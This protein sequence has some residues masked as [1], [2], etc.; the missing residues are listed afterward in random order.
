MKAPST[1]TVAAAVGVSVVGTAVHYTDNYLFIDEYPQPDY[2]N[3]EMV[4]LAWVLLTLIGAAG[5]L[6]FREGKQA[7][8]ALY[9]LVYSYTGL[10]SLGHYAFGASHEFTTKM[11]AFIWMDGIVGGAVAVVAL[12][13]FFTRP[14]R[15]KGS[16]YR[17]RP[18]EPPGP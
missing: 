9:L 11:H 4:A 5:Y 1:R 6:L 2:I 16:T 12:W 8:S 10:S 3:K 17:L 13:V 18:E 15:A 14:A 7:F